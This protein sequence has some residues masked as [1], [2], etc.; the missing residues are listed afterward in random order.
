[1]HSGRVPHRLTQ[2]NA[3][4]KC[5]RLWNHHSDSLSPNLFRPLAL[6]VNQGPHLDF[7]S[8]ISLSPAPMHQTGSNNT[9][10]QSKTVESPS[11]SI[12]ESPWHHL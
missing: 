1:M 5:L 11:H 12:S 9:E 7:L 10:H 3:P 8:S 2:T 4:P 6:M